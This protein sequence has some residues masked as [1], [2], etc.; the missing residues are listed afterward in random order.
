[1]GGTNPVP[2]VLFVH[3][4]IE[5]RSQQNSSKSCV[6]GRTHHGKLKKESLQ[7]KKRNLEAKQSRVPRICVEEHA[8]ACCSKPRPK[9]KSTHMRGCPHIRVESHSAYVH[10]HVA[11]TL[12]VTMTHLPTYRRTTSTYMRGRHSAS[13]SSQSCSNTAPSPE[14][15]RICVEVHA[16]AWKA[17][18]VTS[19][20]SKR[21]PA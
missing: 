13:M 1:M 20:R 7:I 4:N 15:L 9:P 2:N 14:D 3:N 10:R 19:W 17:T 11:T 5:P 6:T 16:Y 18:L 8:Y 12:N 21:D